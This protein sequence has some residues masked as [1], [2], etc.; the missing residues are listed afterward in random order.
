[1]NVLT[2]GIFK[3][4]ANNTW[5]MVADLSAFQQ[6]HPVAHPEPDDFEPDGT[7]FSMVAVRGKLYAVEPNHGELDVVSS[8]GTIRRIADISA[9]QGTLSL[10]LSPTTAISMWG[11]STPFLSWT[12]LQK[13]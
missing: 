4:N 2:N 10:P 7:W 8:D 12:D 13:F 6:A 3:V 5:T 11:I 1:L 9:T